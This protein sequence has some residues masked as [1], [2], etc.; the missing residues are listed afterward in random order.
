[1]S[2]LIHNSSVILLKMLQ[3]P[4]VLKGGSPIK[5]KLNQSMI[6]VDYNNI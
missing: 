6:N 3:E 4:H 5:N 2:S 1:M